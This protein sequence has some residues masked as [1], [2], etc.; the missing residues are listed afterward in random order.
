MGI[1]IKI[2]DFWVYS[3]LPE[4]TFD[5][6]FKENTQESQL[7]IINNDKKL[8]FKNNDKTATLFLYPTMIILAYNS[9]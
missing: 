5:Q 4:V 8:Y 9:F 1:I 6:T 3:K 7:S 2:I